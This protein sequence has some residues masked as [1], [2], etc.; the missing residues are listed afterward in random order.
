MSSIT[1]GIAEAYLRSLKQTTTLIKIAR[2]WDEAK[3]AA[4]LAQ[5]SAPHSVDE[6][7][8]R[9]SL[10]K[11][12][13]NIHSPELCTTWL[14]FAFEGI[15]NIANDIVTELPSDIL[16][17][18][19]DVFLAKAAAGAFSEAAYD[20]ALWLLAQESQQHSV[21]LKFTLFQQ[22]RWPIGIKDQFFYIL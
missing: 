2:S 10:R 19:P 13:A 3:S 1:T 14:N 8:S 20:N 5:T 15:S 22:G 12:A 17:A 6:V 11:Q 7:Q 16:I 21:H 18:S 9:H 4:N